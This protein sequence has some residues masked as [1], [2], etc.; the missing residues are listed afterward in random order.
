MV[1]LSGLLLCF[2]RFAWRLVGILGNCLHVWKCFV[3][4]HLLN[5]ITANFGHSVS[6]LPFLEGS[7]MYNNPCAFQKAALVYFKWD[8]MQSFPLLSW[9]ATAQQ[10]KLAQTQSLKSYSISA[11]FKHMYSLHQNPKHPDKLWF[12]LL[13]TI[14]LQFNQSCWQPHKADTGSCCWWLLGYFSTE[15]NISESVHPIYTK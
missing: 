9:T 6:P 4:T 15:C 10:L 2:H 11:H 7:V 5:K 12:P 1:F 3:K 14:L 13:W 8:E